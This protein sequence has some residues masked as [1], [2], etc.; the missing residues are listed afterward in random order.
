MRVIVAAAVAAVVFSCRW[1]LFSGCTNNIEEVGAVFYHDIHTCIFRS[2]NNEL[3][4][5]YHSQIR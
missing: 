3:R 5:F 2:P 4:S 1:R